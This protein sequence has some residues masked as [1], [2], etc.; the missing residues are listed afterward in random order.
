MELVDDRLLAEITGLMK[1]TIVLAAVLGMCLAIPA[2]GG[3][4]AVQAGSV[5]GVTLTPSSVTLIPGES[6]H[7]TATVTGTGEFARALKWTVNEA[8]GGNSTFGKISDTGLYVTP[9]PA[10]ASVTVKVVSLM[11]ASKF[12][13]PP[14][15]WWRCRWLLA[16]R[17]WWMSARLCMQSTR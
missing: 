14:L 10:P 7:F 17:C 8:V 4:Q 11:D 16:R 15:R 13:A 1:N 9:F 6:K 5:T 2:F 3:D 12:A